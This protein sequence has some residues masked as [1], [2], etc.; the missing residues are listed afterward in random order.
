MG[1]GGAL[2]GTSTMYAVALVIVL[3]LSVVSPALAA[4]ADGTDAESGFVPGTDSFGLTNDD[5]RLGTTNV[6]PTATNETTETLNETSD[7]NVTATE[8]D[9][10]SEE[11]SESDEETETADDA[12]DDDSENE[13]TDDAG[14]DD[15]DN[16][17]ADGDEAAD[18]ADNADDRPVTVDTGVNS[19]EGAGGGAGGKDKGASDDDDKG[20]AGDDDDKGK[21]ASDNASEKAEDASDSD[22]KGEGKDASDNA[23]DEAEDADDD[24]DEKGENTSNGSDDKTENASEN[25]ADKGENARGDADDEAE[26]ASDEAADS[27]ED[28]EARAASDNAADKAENASDNAAHEGEDGDEDEAD[29]GDEDEDGWV[30]SNESEGPPEHANASATVQNATANETVS[31]NVSSADTGD[32][33]VSTVNLTAEKNASYD[34]NVTV[35]NNQPSNAPDYDSEDGGVGLGAI[36]VNHTIADENISN[37][38]FTFRLSQERLA[39]ADATPEEVALYRYHN[40]SW[41]ALNTTFLREVNGTYVFRAVSPG[42][43]DFTAAAQ[44]PEFELEKALV[45][46]ESVTVGDAVSIRVRI[47]NVGDADGS[48]TAKLLFDGEVIATEQVS[49]AA[50]GTRQVEFSRT[51]DTAGI[52][53][54]QVNNA[55]AGTLSVKASATQTESADTRTQRASDR[56]TNVD[57]TDL[58]TKRAPGFGAIAMLAAFVVVLL[59]QL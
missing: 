1:K 18:E 16:E 35:A 13:T 23:V 21:D 15:P 2:G 28:D 59:R 52:Y 53:E 34:V 42:L 10:E 54:V 7:G 5:G 58:T 20:K 57:S 40:G 41:N 44:K 49:I 6:T 48:Y 43:S 39:A 32:V 30:D 9:D 50:N 33:G 3:T 12:E 29:D 22:D 17:T 4:G 36:R 24:A 56:T 8:T 26:N 19:G 11:T 51:P 47:H 46:P 55:S 38:T 27:D 14:D 31:V 45:E 25:A 37:V